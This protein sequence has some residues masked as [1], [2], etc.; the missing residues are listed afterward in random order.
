MNSPVEEAEISLAKAHKV[1][2]GK[3]AM[4]G[5]FDGTFDGNWDA[6]RQRLHVRLDL[7]QMLRAKLLDHV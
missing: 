1:Q 3:F 5:L 6:I 7:G 2:F 4:F